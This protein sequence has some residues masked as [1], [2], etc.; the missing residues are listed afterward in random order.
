MSVVYYYC[1]HHLL[2][3]HARVSSF[4]FENCYSAIRLL[5]RKCEIGKLSSFTAKFGSCIKNNVATQT[6]SIVIISSRF[7]VSVNIRPSLVS[8]RSLHFLD[9]SVRRRAVCTVCLF[10]PATAKDI[11]VFT[12]H[13]SFNFRTT[14][15][16]T[17]QQFIG[18][19]SHAKNS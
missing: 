5:S 1:Y 8:C 10:L 2:C 16:W 11:A 9:H 6:P 12:R 7:P 15:S 18:C 14:L 4:Y 17:L 3:L 19:F 13:H